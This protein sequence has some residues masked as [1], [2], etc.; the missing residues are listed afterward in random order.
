MRYST[1]KM[2]EILKSP[3]AQKIIDYVTPKYGNSYVGLWLFQVIGTQLDDMR[4]WTDEMRKQITPL[5][6]TWGLYYFQ[7]DYGLNLDERL[8][9]I[10]PGISEEELLPETQEII[11]Q[12]RQEIIT[13]IRERSPANPTNIANIIS[14]MTGRNINIIENTAK[15]TFDLIILAGTNT[16]NM[17]AVYKKMKQI[18]PT[19]LTVNYFGQLNINQLKAYTYGQLGAYTYGQIKNGLPIT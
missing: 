14:G 9:A 7:Q 3:E 16:Y 12:A 17:Q 5:K 1:E 15:N 13:K 11:T 10:E 6:A 8:L 19:H 4:T 2:V 18:K